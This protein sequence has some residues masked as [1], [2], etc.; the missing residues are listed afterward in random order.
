[1]IYPIVYLKSGEAV[2]C[3]FKC[4]VFFCFAI[5]LTLA[6]KKLLK[7]LVLCVMMLSALLCLSLYVQFL[8]VSREWAGWYESQIIPSALFRLCVRRVHG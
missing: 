2:L 3:Y 1:M 4:S 7:N 8:C 6:G 5:S